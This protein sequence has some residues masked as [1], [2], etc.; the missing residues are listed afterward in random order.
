[1]K[2]GLWG[3][4]CYCVCLGYYMN[5][6]CSVWVCVLCVCKIQSRTEEGNSSESMFHLMLYE[7]VVNWLKRNENPQVTDIK[8][9]DNLPEDPTLTSSVITST[10]KSLPHWGES[11][12]HLPAAICLEEERQAFNSGQ[13]STGPSLVCHCHAQLHGA[14][15][16]LSACAES[17]GTVPVLPICTAFPKTCCPYLCEP[18]KTPVSITTDLI[19]LE[20]PLLLCKA[21]CQCMLTRQALSLAPPDLSCVFP[22]GHQ[23][24]AA[25]F[26]KSGKR[27]ME[28]L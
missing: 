8:T 3:C 17:W 12:V 23:H 27:K 19:P 4:V 18:R 24:W 10:C 20:F 7:T 14:W 11:K 28:T 25:V 2:V 26:P 9:V 21:P 16:C 22:P 13:K 6:C 15:V 1:M 5:L